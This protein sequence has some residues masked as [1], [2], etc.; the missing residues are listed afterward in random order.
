[1]EL[2]T[3]FILSLRRTLKISHTRTMILLFLASLSV[4]PELVGF[5]ADDCVPDF[6]ETTSPGKLEGKHNWASSGQNYNLLPEAQCNPL[7][8]DFMLDAFDDQYKGCEEVLETDVMPKVLTLEKSA[9]PAFLPAGF[10]DEFGV[11]IGVY[12]TDWPPGHPVYKAFNGKVSL[13]GKSRGDYVLNFHYKALHFYMTRA[14]QLMKRNSRRRH[15]A[16]RG[17]D[18]TFQVSETSLRFGRFTSSSLDVEVARAYHGGLFFQ[19]T[20]C[21]G[22]DIHRI[23]SYPRELEVLIPVAETFRYVREE[24]GVYVLNSTCQLCSYFNCALLGGATGEVLSPGLVSQTAVKAL[25][26]DAQQYGSHK[27]RAA[28]NC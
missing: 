23:S 4:Y 2:L 7:N 28:M 10:R 27:R 1:M 12:T 3:R 17:T 9:N 24:G 25:T 13:A 8:L 21:F 11:A 19:I 5:T 6:E 15:T 26:R 14:L 16:Y 22:V 18:R 20:T